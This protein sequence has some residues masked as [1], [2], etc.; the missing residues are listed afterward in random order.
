MP[1]DLRSK[2]G[3]GTV[4]I[5][6]PICFDDREEKIID[7]AV[8]YLKTGVVETDWQSY[9]DFPVKFYNTGADFT[10][11]EINSIAAITSGGGFIWVVVS[12]NILYKMNEDGTQT[13][14]S[15]TLNGAGTVSEI[16]YSDG[17]LY[18]QRSTT[19]RPISKYGLDSGA[20]LSSFNTNESNDLSAL[21]SDGAHLYTINGDNEFKKYTFAGDLLS[22]VQLA[23]AYQHLVWDGEFFLALKTSPSKY[24]YLNTSGQEAHKEGYA[25]WSATGVTL[26]DF[27]LSGDGEKLF[28]VNGIDVLIYEK[29]IYGGLSPTT[30]NANALGGA[31][32]YWRIK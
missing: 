15:F 18:A 32:V 6:S 28:G 4:P 30:N 17:F 19:G 26:S 22:T 10:P 13:G 25:P 2:S 20:V 23:T 1:I 11:D 9:P 27:T 16:A 24:V 29:G 12:N 7:S 31:T 14:V 8:N 21:G 5:N 3:G